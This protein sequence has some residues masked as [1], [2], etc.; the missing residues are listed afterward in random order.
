MIDLIPA[1]RVRHRAF[2]LLLAGIDLLKHR[3]EPGALP[4]SAT[5]EEALARYEGRAD[6]PHFVRW[7]ALKRMSEALVDLHPEESFARGELMAQ[8]PRWIK[9]GR[10]CHLMQGATQ[11]ACVYRAD[12]GRVIATLGDDRFDAWTHAPVGKSG[13]PQAVDGIIDG[14]AWVERALGLAAL[15]TVP[16]P[17]GTVVL[18]TTGMSADDIQAIKD[19]WEKALDGPQAGLTTAVVEA[20]SAAGPDWD[21]ACPDWEQRIVLG[22]TLVPVQPLFPA[23]AEAALRVFTALRVSEDQTMGDVCRPWA[24][25]FVGAIFGAYDAE[26]RRRLISKFMLLVA[27][28]NCRSTIGLG[29]ALT[30]L[31][32]NLEKS[33]LFF[34]LAPTAEVAN[35]RFQQLHDMVRADPALSELLLVQAHRRTVIHRPTSA[36]LTAIAPG[37]DRLAGRSSSGIVVDDL[38]AFD[39]RAD[40]TLSEAY[41]C[42][43]GQPAGFIVYLAGQSVEPPR[44]VFRKTLDY[45]RLV[46]DGRL[47]DHRFLPVLYEFPAHL[48]QECKHTDPAFFRIPNPNLGASVDTPF[49]LRELEAAKTDGSA[50]VRR[51]LARHLTVEARG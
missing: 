9:Q 25:D 33:A 46:R 19:E 45:A 47:V 6:H 32:L 39:R 28:K 44:G 20:P 27:A 16:P 40:A 8:P 5:E 37:A 42:V 21:T 4:L 24:L 14:M 36:T 34:L 1:V 29:I 30:A 22:Q 13:A 31:L 17:A 15:P 43:V 50:G 23:Q 18:D 2:S 35:D 38:A 48:L 51:F 41:G 10:F 3:L 49:L 12:S 11:L 7:R 26:T